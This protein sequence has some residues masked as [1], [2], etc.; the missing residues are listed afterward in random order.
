[1]LHMPGKHMP[2]NISGSK[3]N[4]LLRTVTNCY[5]VTRHRAAPKATEVRPVCRYCKRRGASWQGTFPTMFG[6]NKVYLHHENMDNRN[7]CTSIKQARLVCLQ[8][9]NAS[10]TTQ[11]HRDTSFTLD[12]VTFYPL[13]VPWRFNCFFAATTNNSLTWQFPQLLKRL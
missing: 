5:S 12:Q 11:K 13:P 4:E 7:H 6:L 9:C 3:H 1:M 8:G 10:C 2:Q